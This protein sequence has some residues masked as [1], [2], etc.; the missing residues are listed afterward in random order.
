MTWL[1]SRGIALI[2][3]Q[4]WGPIQRSEDLYELILVDG[5]SITLRNDGRQLSTFE[6]LQRIIRENFI[7]REKLT[8]LLRPGTREISVAE[9]IRYNLLQSLPYR[10]DTYLNKD[11]KVLKKKCSHLFLPASFNRT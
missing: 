2:I 11:N 10:R 8:L 4:V 7:N 3:V 9:F 1:Q 6:Y 5:S